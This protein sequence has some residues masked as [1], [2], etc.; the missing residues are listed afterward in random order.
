M[1]DHNPAK[2]SQLIAYQAIITSA[3]RQYPLHA[4]LNYDTQFRITTPSDHTLRWDKRHSDLWLER[5]THLLLPLSQV[6][7]HVLIVVRL[8]TTVLFTLHLHNLLV[9]DQSPEEQQSIL[10]TEPQ[11][12]RTLITPDACKHPAGTFTSATT[13]EAT[14]L[15]GH[16][17]RKGVCTRPLPWTPLRLFILKWELSNHPDKAFVR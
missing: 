10:M 16:A 14:T 8:V 13:V 3:S 9:G 15:V 5:I 1:V 17:P 11:Y 12:A 2:A 6:S 7:F 4:W